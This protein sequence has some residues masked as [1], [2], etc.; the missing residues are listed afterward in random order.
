MKLI[1][2]IS[3]IVFVAVVV[4]PIIFF[5]TTPDAI[6]EIDN[7]KLANNPFQAGGDLT[8]NI[9]N[10]VNDRIGL[11]DFAITSYTILNDKL[12]GKMVHPSY[13]YGKDGYVFGAGITT[14]N[15]FSDY[16]IAFADM[17]AEI[18]AYCTQRN[19]PFLFVFNPAKPAV[20]PDKLAAGTNYNRQWVDLFLAELDQR[21]INYLD[22]TKTMMDLRE[23]GLNGFNHK[24][25]ANHWNDLGAFYGTQAMLEQLSRACDT[26]H[27]NTL[28]EFTAG[29]MLQTS[30]QVSKFPIKESVPALELKVPIS[31]IGS[32]YTPALTIH[33]SYPG[34]G[35]A[36]NNSEV[37]S[38]TPKALVFQ[39][40]Y[41]NGYGY[42]YLMNAF[43][44][45]IYVHDY[46]N[47]LNFPY[48]FN[49]FQP[50][51]V[52][53]E[54]AEYTF[55][56]TYFDYDTMCRIDYNP[57]LPLLTEDQYTSVLVSKDDLSVT[58][59]AALTTIQWHTNQA[60]NYVWMALDC[61]YDMQKIEGGY[62][63]TIETSA[64][65][66]AGEQLQIFASVQ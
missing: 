35:Y 60:Y 27:V 45:Y 18:Q 51:C 54:V 65:T 33:P 57:A 20:Y 3:L 40:S 58:E 30:L 32:Q 55:S 49:I 63:V 29:E 13:I 17:V 47:V 10:Y 4:V 31:S 34:F 61:I 64:Y 41:M 66:D 7:R 22:N 23:Q 36:V 62:Q 2:I 11:R 9:Q 39:G 6:S 15:L 16:H 12:F 52:I 50:E 42:K 26:V 1:R 25:D 24:Y 48:Y 5:N 44:E 53:F 46:Q 8:V 37:V 38:N 56:N 14:Y 21:G 19:V 43:R 28:E 59:G